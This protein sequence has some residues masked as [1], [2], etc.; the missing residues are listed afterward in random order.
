MVR[1]AEVVPSGVPGRN[2]SERVQAMFG[3]IVRRYDLMNRLMTLGMD[4]GWRRAAI[5]AADV[6]GKRVLDLG[7]GTGDLAR[8]AL[9]AGA[10][11]VIGADFVGTMLGVARRKCDS[12]LRLIQAD[13]LHLPF[14]D[15]SFECVINGFLLRNVADLPAAL[16]EMGR[17]LRPGGQLACL[18]ITHPPPSV[19]P[20][21]GL[22]FDRLVPLL[23]AVVTGE[24]D[25]YRYLPRSLG[26]LPEAPELS[27]L[28]ARAGF[29]QVRFHRLGLG[30]VALHLAR[31]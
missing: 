21:F 17:V 8:E 30:M 26:P 20:L 7:T 13:A 18:E 31:R 29:T 4:G 27:R 25:A 12:R 16:R 10:A 3:Q 19:A 24:R 22:Y 1:A 23:G 28:I 9:R 6:R 2:K 11:E 15:Q 14:V 5:Q